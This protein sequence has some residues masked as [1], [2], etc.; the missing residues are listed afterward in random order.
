M[1][2][3][4]HS[5]QARAV[6]TPERERLLREFYPNVGSAAIAQA[7]HITANQ[8]YRKARAMGLYKSHAFLSTAASGRMQAGHQQS[9]KS[10]RFQPGQIP[11]NRGTHFAAGGRS[12]ET[13]FKPGRKPE[14][15]HNYVPIGTMKLSPDGYLLR[16][17]TDA[18]HL[19]PV[20]R[21]KPVH[22]LVWEATHGAVPNGWV[23]AF[24]PGQFT[25]QVELITV[26]RLECISRADNAKRNS[27]WHK[28]P[29]LMRL[30]VLKGHIIRQVNRIQK[31]EH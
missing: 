20:R 18:P 4:R 22:R 17:V 26:D 5:Y 3:N 8:V 28:D 19:A 31:K 27:M 13:R 24:R 1:N 12:A 14:E 15:A 7:L 2:R 10:T 11:W 6:W 23:V 21:W 29:E 9:G 16:K 30:H 25:N